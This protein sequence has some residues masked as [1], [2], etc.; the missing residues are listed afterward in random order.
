MSENENSPLIENPP[1]LRPSTIKRQILGGFLAL[2]SNIAF[3]WYN[4]YI[5]KFKQDVSD[6]LLV[7][8]IVTILI[9]GSIS[10]VC[11]ENFLPNIEQCESKKQYWIKCGLLIFQVFLSDFK[12]NAFIKIFLQMLKLT[13][14]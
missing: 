13:S 5:K 12:L 1:D 4:Y 3:V 6:V 14:V 10:F 7:R 9:F 8:S 2:M 11:K